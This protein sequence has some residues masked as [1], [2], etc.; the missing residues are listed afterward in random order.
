MMKRRTAASILALLSAVRFAGA[1]EI[2]A[3]AHVSR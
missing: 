1:E 2:S 3:D